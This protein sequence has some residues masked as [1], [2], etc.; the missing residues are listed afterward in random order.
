L[1]SGGGGAGGGAGGRREADCFDGN[2]GLKA[3]FPPDDFA[4]AGLLAG[5]PD[6]LDDVF[7][8]DGFEPVFGR[9]GIFSGM[10]YRLEL[11]HIFNYT[12]P[13]WKCAIYRRIES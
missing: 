11:E 9:K 2:A 7:L 4:A 10:V 3:G 5:L 6:P 8:G 12:R 1:K 13:G